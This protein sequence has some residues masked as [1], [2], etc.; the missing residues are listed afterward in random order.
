[1]IS[2]LLELK[3]K[4]FKVCVHVA[5]LLLSIVVTIPQTGYA[6]S[7]KKDQIAKVSVNKAGAVKRVYTLEMLG[8]KEDLH[9]YGV[10]GRRKVHFGIRNDEVV[11][12]A[13]LDLEYSYSPA[14]LNRIS[15]IN[16]LLNGYTV[17]SY[18]VGKKFPSEG[19]LKISL[20]PYMM[21]EYNT[22]TFQLIGH[23]T[24][25]ECEYPNHTSLWGVISKRSILT[26]KTQKINFKADL[27]HLPEPFFDK[28]DGSQLILPV[29]FSG[30]V[31]LNSIKAAGIVASWFGKYADYRGAKFP[32]LFDSLP[33][34]GNAV[35][36][37]S[38][39]TSA[40]Q[41][42]ESMSFDGA[43]ISIRA[44]PN[45]PFGHL[46]FVTGQDDED[47]LKTATALALGQVML[48]GIS[49][50]VLSLE[51]P[52]VRRAYDAPRWLPSDRA[53]TFGELTEQG[54]LQVEGGRADSIRVKFRYPPDLF[55]WRDAGADVYLKHR[56]SATSIEGN[57]R[58]NISFNKNFMKSQALKVAAMDKSKADWWEKTSEKWLDQD[59]FSEE[60]F[61]IPSAWFGFNNQFEFQYYLEGAVGKCQEVPGRYFRGAISPDSTIDVSDVPHFTKMPNIG[62]FSKSG[63][64][65]TKQADLSETAVIF[66][67]EVDADSIYA[68]L[69]LMAM[70]GNSTGY[71]VIRVAVDH[72]AAIA[73]YDDRD[74]LVIGSLASA[75]LF[76]HLSSDMPVQM[77]AGRLQM[78]DMSSVDFSEKIFFGKQ[79]RDDEIE[80]GGKLLFESGGNLGVITSFES[81]W[82]SGR[83]VVVVAASGNKSVKSVAD[84][85]VGNS[86]LDA[87]YGDTVFL[88]SAINKGEAQAI[89]INKRKTTKQQAHRQVVYSERVLLKEQYDNIVLFNFSDEYYAGELPFWTWLFWWFSNSPW[90]LFI[91]SLIAVT[92]VGLVAYTL[93]RSRAKRRLAGKSE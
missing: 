81:P 10:D 93:M 80:R 58:L 83:S 40:I 54:L 31:S 76:K 57:G 78:N 67:D 30:N 29:V 62:M 14:L 49:S 20:N 91:V 92:L 75:S 71:P 16:V 8:A 35:V 85:I 84:S 12:S 55:S 17:A 65:F 11:T 15:Q 23:Y 36:L 28:R 42:V 90:A 18:P 39:K 1:M 41:G 79:A 24:I 87:V 48:S 47:L 45:D 26:M 69:E 77:N 34:R 88:K 22:I 61:N 64:P 33:K 43:T 37:V 50:R 72:G 2:M 32:V 4:Y 25:E 51:M 68:F 74:L 53:A 13:Q 52:P 59:A 82:K 70:M 60:N 46:L 38:G 3:E 27:E 89:K 5:I 73:K 7:L 66:P 44:N 9:L 63:Y 21:D 56:Y 6:A 19:S 86:N